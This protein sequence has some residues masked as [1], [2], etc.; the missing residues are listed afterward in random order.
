MKTVSLYLKRDS[1]AKQDGCV[2]RFQCLDTPIV[3]KWLS[4]LEGELRRAA[5]L[6]RTYCFLGFPNSPRKLE[7]ICHQINQCINLI[8]D[9]GWGGTYHIYERAHPEMDQDIL[10]K[11]HHHFELLI[12]QTWNYSKYIM[13]APSKIQWA[14]RLLNN[15]I[16]EFEMLMHSKSQFE[17]NPESVHAWIFTSF[18]SD[19]RFDLADQDY[20]NFVIDLD[21]GDLV[22]HYC[23][24][25]KTHLDAFGH[26][27]EHIE[28]N[29]ISGL[30]YYSGS[31]DVSFGQPMNKDYFNQYLKNFNQW[32]RSKGLDPENK[33][34]GIGQLLLGKLIRSDFKDMT[35]AQIRDAIGK[36]T[37]IEAIEINY[38]NGFKIKREYS[39]YYNGVEVDRVCTYNESTP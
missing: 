17:R 30:R 31:F 7:H 18:S 38:E 36:N 20:D 39:D 22:M 34:L 6:E 16:H 19:N 8:N 26:Q 12:G 13:S 37:Y 23:M 3:E 5:P 27:D 15:Q 14:I 9:F 25:G 24:L 1:L 35:N 21:F 4:A 32:M 10:N 11:L 33:K 29:N 2:I 28:D